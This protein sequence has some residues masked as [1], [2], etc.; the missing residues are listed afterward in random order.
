MERNNGLGLPNEVFNQMKQD[1][2]EAEEYYS[3][4]ELEEYA[5]KSHLPHGGLTIIVKNKEQAKELNQIIEELTQEEID[6]L[7]NQGD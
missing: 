4:D 1:A 6:N 3:L 5:A 2:L 7:R